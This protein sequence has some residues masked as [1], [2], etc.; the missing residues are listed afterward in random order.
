MRSLNSFHFGASTMRRLINCGAVATGFLL[1][2]AL[3]AQATVINVDL[4]G[5]RGAE[6]PPTTYV[7]TSP[8]GSGTVW[9]AV[10]V[11]NGGYS[12]GSASFTT[13]DNQ[14][15][16]GSG[17]L[18]QNG[19][20]THVGFTIAP[21][22]VD[23]AGTNALLNDYIFNNS[24]SNS[25]TA[26]FTISG[27]QPGTSYQLYLYTPY[28]LATLA[29]VTVS[30]GTLTAFT[31]PGGSFTA[32]STELFTGV[33]N[34]SGNITGAL[35]GGLNVV[36]GF[37]LVGTTPEPSAIAL[38]SLALVGLAWTV[39]R[40]GRVGRMG[41]LLPCL[42]ASAI[43]LM[44]SAAQASHYST[45]VLADN[46]VA[47]WQFAEATGTVGTP[48]PGGTL[49]LNSGSL[50]SSANGTYSNSNATVGSLIPV[51]QFYG[52]AGSNN[53][54]AFTT[55]T[56]ASSIAGSDAGFPSGNADRTVVAWVDT[57]AAAGAWHSAAYYGSSNTGNA[58]FLGAPQANS[59]AMGASQYGG[60][61]NGTTAINN[62]GW[63]M[64]AFTV[65]GTTA[66]QAS[67]TLY[68]DGH[69]DGTNSMQTNTTLGQF[70][71]GNDVG[72]GP[73]SGELAQVSIFNSALSASQVGAL[74][75][76]AVVPEPGS[77]ALMALGLVGLLFVGY[78]R[79]LG[80]SIA[81]AAGRKQLVV[82]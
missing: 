2:T 18:D 52:M 47:Y 4:Q 64:L 45:A 40:A 56:S 60:D 73:L 13:G 33:V 11:G 9:N 54:V 19:V 25:S 59:N 27:L 68:V 10:T 65:T 74:Y 1:A 29:G 44:S 58:I 80:K 41:A 37:T 78:R 7:G 23:N 69:A 61:L 51:S 39:R 3:V 77:M 49:S 16:S 17:F 67:Y 38:M 34:G 32:T 82:S 12:D 71:L 63:H 28:G 50:G 22:G 6:S 48:I 79:G 46:P 57:T 21:V 36:S 24:A 75:Q 62:G 42:F 66:G 81:A 72:G 8:A 76:A 20:G 14:T 5:Y 53:S 31:P 70:L 55:G 30:G 15:A 43:A 35:G 26:P